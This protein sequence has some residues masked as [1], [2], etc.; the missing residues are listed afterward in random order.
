MA[1]Q[2]RVRVECKRKYSDPH[3]NFKDMIQDFKRKVSNSG[4]LHDYKEHQYYESPSE[5]NRK[6]RKESEKK[7]QMEA[8]EKKILGGE[9]VKASAGLIKKVMSNLAKN[10]RD[11]K[12]WNN[13]RKDD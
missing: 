10:K 12:K 7:Q 8:L 11:N 6:K 9:T 13:Y 1:N 2:V 4:I 5:K 3:R